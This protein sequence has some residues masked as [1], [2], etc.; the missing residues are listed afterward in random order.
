MSSG[1]RRRDGSPIPSPIGEISWSRI[2]ADESHEM[3]KRQARAC[4]E[5]TSNC[6]WCITAT[7]GDPRRSAAS[8]PCEQYRRQLRFLGMHPLCD[9]DSMQNLIDTEGF[10]RGALV[11]RPIQKMTYRVTRE[12]L[13]AERRLSLRNDV[14]ITVGMTDIE[15]EVYERQEASAN[16]VYAQASCS[17]RQVG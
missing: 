10:P 13:P 11:Y 14:T 12:Q 8:R 7:P 5:L 1:K 16:Q 4:E 2:L 3:S 17:Q 15:R 9:K 6:R